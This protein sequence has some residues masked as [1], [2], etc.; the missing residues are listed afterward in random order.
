MTKTSFFFQLHLEY[1]KAAGFRI[2]DT[3]CFSSLSEILSKFIRRRMLETSQLNWAYHKPTYCNILIYSV[4]R[5]RKALIQK[6]FCLFFVATLIFHW[7]ANSWLYFL[8]QIIQ[9]KRS[10]EHSIYLFLSRLDSK[11]YIFITEAFY[12][13]FITTQTRPTYSISKMCWET[14][15]HSTPFT[16]YSFLAGFVL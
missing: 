2:Q 8:L 10:V 7:K 14:D 15:L 6:L 4:K 11:S 16:D 5:W 12:R 3:I 1:L 9:V 13:S